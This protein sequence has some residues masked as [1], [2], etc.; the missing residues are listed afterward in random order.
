M[1]A[2]LEVNDVTKRFGGLTAVKNATFKLEK[3]EFT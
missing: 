1:T 3:G 2:L